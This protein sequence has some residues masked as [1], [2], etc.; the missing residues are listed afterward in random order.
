MKF[1][2]INVVSGIKSTG[3]ICSDL[4][5]KLIEQ[6]HDVRIAYG[7]GEVPIEYKDISYKIGSDLDVYTH[8]FKSRIF[9]ASG[10]G[11][12]FV[13]LRFIDR[14]K[15]YNPDVIHLHNIHGYY[16]NIKVLFDYLKI[17]GKKIIWTLHDC[18]SFTGHTAYCDSINC[19]RWVEGCYN[20]P[21]LK[22]YPKSYID[23][24]NQNWNKKKNI[25]I[26]TPNLTIVT[27]SLWLKKMVK[28]SYLKDY[29]TIVINNGIN[30]NIF[31]KSDS[32]FRKKYELENEIILLGV[33]TAWDK[34]KGLLDYYELADKLDNN[35]KIVLVGLSEEQSDNLPPN[36]I[37]IKKTDTARELAKIYSEADLLLNL[38]YCENYPTVN[39][40]S[41]ACGTPV[42]TYKTGGSPEIIEK[43]GGIIVDKFDID[44][45]I[46]EV[47]ALGGKHIELNF[48]RQ[49]N[50]IKYMI[51]NYM[52]LY[53]EG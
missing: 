23:R 41:M 19:T 33:A 40:E 48:D 17:S 12:K 4:A 32:E 28:K 1:L 27:P 34:N 46:N 3:R 22:E 52:K 6:G 29:R 51:K 10:F 11:S 7:R 18:W 45:V 24:S 5:D 14:I 37:G 20:C 39:I 31:K 42:L 44:G 30:T 35:F 13:T 36:I 9:D 43:Y 53:E 49:E 21:L 2:F 50:D 38:S 16:I 26:N 8:V 15:D 47:K 25:F